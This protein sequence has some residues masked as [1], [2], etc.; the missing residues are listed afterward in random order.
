[1]VEKN[2]NRLVLICPNASASVTTDRTVVRQMLLNLLSN[3]AKFTA[4][5][6]IQLSVTLNEGGA[7]NTL[8]LAVTD[9][10]IGMRKEALSRIFADYE[11][12]ELSTSSRYGGTG[13]GLSLT[14]RQAILLGGEISVASKHGEGSCFT[15]RL[16]AHLDAEPRCPE[17]D[18]PSPAH[19]TRRRR[20]CRMTSPSPSTSLRDPIMSSQMIPLPRDTSAA[21][22]SAAPRVLVVD[23][24]QDNREILTRRLVRRGFEVVE[25]NGGLPPALEAVE[26]QRFD[27]V[28]LDIM[29]PGHCRATRCCAGSGRP[30]RRPSCRSSW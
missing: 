20:V 17:P 23:D 15:I 28:L 30:A 16:P 5:G 27:L 24:V 9:S 22:A 14:K 7:E 3:A 12:A 2:G 26:T 10:G 11:Q 29:M 6:T 4:N 13:L 25:A 18:T 1:M 21:A 8:T 19:A